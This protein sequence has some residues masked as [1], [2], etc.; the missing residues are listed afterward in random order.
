[1]AKIRQGAKAPEMFS[2]SVPA[3]EM[4][5]HRA[6]FGWPTVSGPK[7]TIFW[8]HVVKI[9]PFNKFFLQRAALQALY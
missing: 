1:V 4:A 5:K 9:L 3:Q 8:G 2:Y 6:R 7:F